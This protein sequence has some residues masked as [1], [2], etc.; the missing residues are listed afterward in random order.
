MFKLI[1]K[2]IKTT[3]ILG[4]GFFIGRERPDLI[5]TIMNKVLG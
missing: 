3:I 1:G 5:E 2:L 4:I